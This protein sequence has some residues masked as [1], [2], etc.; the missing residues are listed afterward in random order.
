MCFT[1]APGSHL[2]ECSHCLHFIVFDC[3]ETNEGECLPS[4]RGE[5]TG[6]GTLKPS[7]STTCPLVLS[8]FMLSEVFS[9]A[10]FYV[11]TT[12]QG[13]SYWEVAE[14]AMK[15]TSKEGRTLNWATKT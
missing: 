4:E 13:S 11:I 3:N 2:P 10:L 15:L 8:P 14:K 1:A 6:M 7:G 5:L 12:T 9:N